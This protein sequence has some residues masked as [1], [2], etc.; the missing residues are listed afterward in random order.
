MLLAML[1]A[2]ELRRPTV[3]ARAETGWTAP[4][5]KRQ[6]ARAVV[7]RTSVSRTPVS[8]PTDGAVGVGDGGGTFTVR[9]V[10]AQGS[11]LVADLAEANALAMVPEAVTRVEPGDELECLLLEGSSGLLEVAR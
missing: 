11:H 7:S 6:Y 10:G 1:G 4:A 3:R 9:P 2:S 5:G 8:L